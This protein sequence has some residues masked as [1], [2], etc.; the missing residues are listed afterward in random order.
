MTAT[1]PASTP[2]PADPAA[3]AAA[4]VAANRRRQR[5]RRI[6]GFAS[7][8]IL[9]AAA[10]LVVKLLS[11]YTFANQAIAAHESA[12]AQGTIAAARG[13]HPLNWFEPYLA[14]YNS[15][16]GQ[17]AA[18]DLDAARSSLE[19][20]VVLVDGLQACAVR[21]NLALV[22]EWQGDRARAAGDADAAAALYQE[23]LDL[24]LGTPPECG[25]AEADEQSPDPQRSLKTTLDE[26]EQ[27]LREKLQPPPPVP[28]DNEQDAEES[29]QPPPEDELD[30]IKERLEQ[31][32][33]ERDERE[34]E[35]DGTGGG[36][37]RPW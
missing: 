25:T 31:G 17:A 6:V 13:Q 27:R 36:V 19:T 9:L 33:S 20:A 18:G 14:H 10:V 23:A 22:V 4:L 24:V 32:Q 29:P 37:E 8:P 1:L 15:G 26:Q 2:A 16:V 34:Q 3:A 12:D 35:D 7:I 30:E 5:I 21:S 28:D 11:M